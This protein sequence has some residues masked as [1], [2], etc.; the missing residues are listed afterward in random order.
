MVGWKVYKRTSVQSWL[1]DWLE[2]VQNNKCV[3]LAI[4]EGLL[5]EPSS[6]EE[7]S[8]QCEAEQSGIDC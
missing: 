2:S 1:S 7:S 5:W 6:V 8:Q 4:K 3:E